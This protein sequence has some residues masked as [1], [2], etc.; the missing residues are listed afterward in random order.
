VPSSAKTQVR[1]EEVLLNLGGAFNLK[2]NVFIAPKSGIYEFNFDGHKTGTS[3]FLNISLRLNGKD[4]VNAFSDFMEQHTFR[5]LISMHSLLKLKKGDRVDLYVKQGNLLDDA[6]DGNNNVV[7]HTQFTGKLLLED[8]P[9]KRLT[10][11]VYFNVQKNVGYCEPQSSI[12]FEI[13]NINEGEAFD[14]KNQKFISPIAGIYEFIV[15]GFK[16][17]EKDGDNNDELNLSMR[18]NGTPVA[19]S[20]ADYINNCYYKHNFHSSFSITSILKLEEGDQIDLFLA[21]GCLYDDTNH[22]TQFTGKLLMENK[23][24]KKGRLA[25]YFNVQKNALFSTANAVIPFEVSVFNIGG[26]FSSTEHFFR[27]PSS[28]IYEFNVAGI[29]DDPKNILRIALRLNG[30]PVAFIW[31]DFVSGHGLYTPFFLHHV[32]KVKEGDRIDLFN[33]GEGSRL[34][35]NEKK[36]T[37]FTGKLLIETE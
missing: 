32:M 16:T 28:G 24:D 27:A 19:N 4:A 25:K 5:N 15:K 10:T 23:S 21:K 18:L 1:F 33:V 26:A 3:E 9:Y 11:P 2:E 7:Q 13:V 20:W 17:G 30:K 31:A 14:L 22:L 12:P 34:F 35:D 36:T 8:V 37:H 29:K 6:I